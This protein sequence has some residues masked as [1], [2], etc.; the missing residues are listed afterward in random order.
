MP[1]DKDVY[2]HKIVTLRA[3]KES[4]QFRTSQEL[5]SSHETD[6]G[7]RFLLRSVIEAG[8]SPKAMLDMGCGYG[9]LGLALKKLYPESTVEMVD[10]DALAIEYARRNAALNGLEGV[11]INGSTGYDDVK[12]TDFDLIVSNI[13]GKA[14]EPVIAYLLREAR[15]YLTPGGTAAIV[16]VGALEETVLKILQETPGGEIIL[17]Q[18]KPGHAVFH[19]KFNAKSTIPKPDGGGVERGVY[20]RENVTMRAAGLDYEIHTAYGMPEFDSLSYGSEMLAAGLKESRG[21]DIKSAAVFNP[22]Q[23]HAPVI[24][25]KLLKPDSISLVDRD[26]LAL[27]YSQ[28]NLIR[29]GFPAERIKVFHQSGAALPVRTDLFAGTLRDEGR[30]ANLQT[31]EQVTDSVSPGGMIIISGGSTQITRAVE[32]VEAERRLRIIK[33]ERRRGYSLLMMEY[34][35]GN[36]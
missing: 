24:L 34:R 9:T 27:R 19:Y 18:S 2:F 15:H 28:L 23:G 10:R 36:A 35:T 11:E 31:L 29:N 12:R 14:G 22:G 3:G 30:E 5:F 16:I 20:H 7:T 8:Y 25:W 17:R 1:M 32:R 4:L 6:T 21:R 33:R 13:P 26:L